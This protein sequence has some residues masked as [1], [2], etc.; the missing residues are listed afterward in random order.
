MAVQKALHILNT[1]NSQN[2]SNQRDHTETQWWTPGPWHHILLTANRPSGSQSP[3]EAVTLQFSSLQSCS[4]CIL[5][6][7]A[8]P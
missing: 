1:G 8:G 7:V 6:S 2:S 3:T 5:K 4:Y